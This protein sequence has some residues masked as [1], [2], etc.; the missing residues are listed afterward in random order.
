M[1][2]ITGAVWTSGQP[3]SREALDDMTDILRHRGPDGRGTYWQPCPDGS[4]VAL[5]H[6]RL[7][8][9]DLATGG[10]PLANEDQTV[11]VTFNGEIYNYRELRAA[12]VAA[13]HVFRTDTDTEVLVHLYEDHGP[14]LVDQLRGMFAFAIWDA[15]RRRLLL[16]RDRLGQ[17]PLVYR[18]EPGRLL[19]ASEIKSLLRAPG[20]PRDIDLGAI[21]AYLAYLYVPHPRTIFRGI[22]KLPP[23][24]VAVFERDRL[25]VRRYWRPDFEARSALSPAQL[26]TQLRERLDESVRLRLR[27]DV[28]VGAFLSGGLDSTTIVGL[29]QA[30]ATTPV[31]TFTVGFP[32]AGFDETPHAEQA[33]RHLQTRHRQLRVT[34]DGLDLLPTLTWHFDEPF[35]DSSAIPTWHIS[36]FARR[37]VKVALTGDGGDELLAGYPR[38]RTVHRLAQLDRLPRAMRAAAARCGRRWLSANGGQRSWSRRLRGRL[39][40]LAEPGPQR[41]ARWVATFSDQLRHD[42]YSDPYRASV[43]DED[44]GALLAQAARCCAGRSAGKQAT[45]VD[46]LHYLPGA[47]LAKVDIM[48]MAHGLEC[49]SPLLD[50]HVVELALS[51][52]FRQLARG[53]RPKP[54]IAEAFAELIPAE[55][56]RRPKAGFSPPMG[57]WFRHELDEPARA[58]LLDPRSLGRGYFSGP[59]IERLL[60]EHA[61]GAWDHGERIWALVCLESWH[62]MFVDAV[63][64]VAPPA[65]DG[66][67]AASD[68]RQCGPSARRDEVSPG[69]EADAVVAPTGPAGRR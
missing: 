16:A 39:E 68:P 63:P 32:V 2:G 34:P 38:Y 61:A 28:P 25:E 35:A 19:F 54:L 62:Q 1:C 24:H 29:M 47:L 21:D 50:H 65:V 41:L 36:E 3:V 57:H 10:Q 22:S 66:G 33:A 26:R 48:S 5:G 18:V 40:A 42:L 17:K 4:G 37:H 7:S 13:G 44:A 6:R 56:R 52:P 59:A 31:Q 23:G 51:I 30:Q 9:I 67:T 58:M 49:R 60:A 45:I 14:D 55:L 27:S 46:L 69:V 12:L 53:S 11:W 15:R 64:D 20:V 8:I 43:A